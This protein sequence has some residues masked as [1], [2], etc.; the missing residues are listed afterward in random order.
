[1]SLA[2]MVVCVLGWRGTVHAGVS[3][4]VKSREFPAHFRRIFS[5]GFYRG[6]SP[7]RPFKSQRRH[8]T[9]RDRWNVM[10]LAV[11]DRG[12]P[13]TWAHW[14]RYCCLALFEDLA[15]TSDDW[16]SPAGFRSALFG[17]RQVGG[18]SVVR[19]DA[20]MAPMKDPRF[21]DRFSHFRRGERNAV[22][23]MHHAL[24][25]APVW[26]LLYPKGVDAF[27]DAKG[28]VTIEWLHHG[29]RPYS[30][31][32]T[33]KA[34]RLRANQIAA[35]DDE[36]RFGDRANATRARRGRPKT[37]TLPVIDASFEGQ[38][39]RP[40]L[41]GQ[42]TTWF[43]ADGTI[44]RTDRWIGNTFDGRHDLPPWV[45]RFEQELNDHWLEQADRKAWRAGVSAHE[46]Q[47]GKRL[48]VRYPVT[49]IIPANLDEVIGRYR[50]C[51]KK[52]T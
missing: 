26:K 1:M 48:R 41:H 50:A 9:E 52:A 33:T 4:A 51:A 13:S 18:A 31:R 17:A 16:L 43:V 35:L 8:V 15:I 19:S 36:Q 5:T 47:T 42:R 46:K 45:L 6:F 39:S 30:G 27:D 24:L 10:L 32:V 2:L 38:V 25:L 28:A 7:N 34:D 3:L 29:A 21:A 20:F 49:G 14:L 44:V 23:S 40:R 37:S 11:A 12:G 22:H